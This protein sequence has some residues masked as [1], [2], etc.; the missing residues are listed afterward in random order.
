MAGAL[1]LFA[2]AEDGMEEFYRTILALKRSLPALDHG[3]LDYFAVK[4]DDPRIFTLLRKL[5]GQAVIPVVNIADRI[6]RATLTVDTAALG[7]RGSRFLVTDKYDGSVIAGS[8]G[9]IWS[10]AELASI[11]VAV[12]A[13]AFRFL[14]IAL[15]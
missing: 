7:L 4:S 15:A 13:F 14:E 12:D 9:V 1:M 8:S 3:S 11:P 10:A 6:S 5:D 2:C